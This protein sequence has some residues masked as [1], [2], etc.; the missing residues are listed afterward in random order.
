MGVDAIYTDTNRPGTLRPMFTKSS[1]WAGYSINGGVVNNGL[2]QGAA[3]R[4]LVLNRS[5]MIYYED[6]VQHYRD[7]RDI[8]NSI[9]YP[10]G[11]TAMRPGMGW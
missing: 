1:V 10:D 9:V 2:S 5:G 7:W 4:I 3:S 11:T 8:L 6:P